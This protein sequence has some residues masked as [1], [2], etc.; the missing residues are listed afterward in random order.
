MG[1]FALCGISLSPI[2]GGVMTIITLKNINDGSV[3]EVS[4]E[5]PY[6]DPLI[7]VREENPRIFIN[8]KWV[9]RDSK[10]LVPDEFNDYLNL[11]EIGMK[12]EDQFEVI[13]IEK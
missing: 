10:K 13:N 3:L 6:P 2:L 7:S 11:A 9:F 12:I 1:F 5:I 4:L 8:D